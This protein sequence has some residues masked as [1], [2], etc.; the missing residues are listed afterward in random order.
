MELD[1][2]K[3]RSRM[4][5]RGDHVRSAGYRSQ[6]G[7]ERRSGLMRD[8]GEVGAVSSAPT[9]P[10]KPYPVE[11]V[12]APSRA[13]SSPETLRRARV[14]ALRFDFT[15]AWLGAGLE[16]LQQVPGNRRDLLDRSIEDG[17]V[18]L[19]RLVV[20]RQLS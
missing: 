8:A 16:R 10:A 3:R 7:P 11:L 12:L 19:R 14:S 1:P 18:R 15:I 2:G 5:R 17:L 4:D 13:S 9:S 20:A 6:A